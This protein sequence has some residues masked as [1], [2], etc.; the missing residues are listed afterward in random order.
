[1]TSMRYISVFSFTVIFLYTVS[2]EKLNIPKE[3]LVSIPCPA[4]VQGDME[5]PCES[6]SDCAEDEQCCQ[7]GKESKYCTTAVAPNTYMINTIMSAATAG[8]GKINGQYR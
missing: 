7:A 3:H 4:I 5:I 6:D 2:A 1:M 8:H